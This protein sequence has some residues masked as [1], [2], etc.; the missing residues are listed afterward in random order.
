VRTKTG[1]VRRCDRSAG[2]FRG[3]FGNVATRI[4]TLNELT[5]IELRGLDPEVEFFVRGLG[6][7]NRGS[8]FVDIAVRTR[9]GQ[10]VEFVQVVKTPTP[11]RELRAL[12]LINQAFPD[13]PTRF[14]ISGP[15]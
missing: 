2:R 6:P 14:V 13:V 4:T 5:L 9:P 3:R 7:R 8:V 12:S 11:A 15:R 1:G 10:L